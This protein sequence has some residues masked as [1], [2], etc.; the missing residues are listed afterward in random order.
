VVGD[1][2]D[3]AGEGL[4]HAL[5]SRAWKSMALAMRSSRPA[6][7]CCTLIPRSNRPEQT[8]TN[9][10]RSRWAGSMFAWILKTSPV[11]AGS[12]GWTSAWWSGAA[13]AAGRSRRTCRAAP[14]RRT[15]RGRAEEDGRLA[16]GE[17]LVEGEPRPGLLQELDVEAELLGVVPEELVERGV[18]EAREVDRVELR[19]P[20]GTGGS[21]CGGGGRAPSEA[22]P[23]P[24]GHASGTA[25][26][27]RLSSMSASRSSGSRPSR[28]SLLMNVR[29]GVSRRR[30]TSMSWRVRLS[31]P[32][33]E[34]ITMSAESTAVRTR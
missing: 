1:A 6:R 7:W 14:P 10:I 20:S 8:R 3:V 9:A 34:S 21:G 29:M 18:V 31:T 16:A 2:D 32:F 19:R 28:S 17:V 22:A 23:L 13:A 5:R 25:T 30:Q 11:N 26:M 24:T 4:L 33:T 12:S 15:R 27:F